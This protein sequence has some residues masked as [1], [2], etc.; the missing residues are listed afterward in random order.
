[1]KIFRLPQRNRKLL[2]E[3]TPLQRFF[4][5][6]LILLLFGAVVC[7]LWLNNERH[8]ERRMELLKRPASV[9]SSSVGVEPLHREC[10]SF[11]AAACASFRTL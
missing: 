9:Q 8:L 6:L 4:R 10:A 3:E 11:S 7:G 2:D 1:M 5:L